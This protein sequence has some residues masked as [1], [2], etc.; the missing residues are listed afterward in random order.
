MQIIFWIF[1]LLLFFFLP[2]EISSWIIFGLVMA[3]FG[4]EH[5]PSEVTEPHEDDYFW[6][7]AQKGRGRGRDD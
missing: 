4:L 5:P 6:D 1:C 2:F 7:L 3:G